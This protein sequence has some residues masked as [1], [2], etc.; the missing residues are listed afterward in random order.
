MRKLRLRKA[1][2]LP[3]TSRAA[4]LA[5]PLCSPALGS[6]PSAAAPEA[7]PSRPGAQ[8]FQFIIKVEA[9]TL[10]PLLCVRYVPD[11]C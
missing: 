5:R 3:N 1:K 6:G 4:G 7:Q 9:G 10:E 11:M 8:W 2:D